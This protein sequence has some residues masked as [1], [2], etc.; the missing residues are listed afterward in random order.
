MTL[1][2]SSSRRAAGPALGISGDERVFAVEPEFDVP[3]LIGHSNGWREIC[4]RCTWF[5]L[6]AVNHEISN[7][8]LEKCPETGLSSASV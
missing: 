5:T 2:V 1:S 6:L 7:R 4:D 8:L 3:A